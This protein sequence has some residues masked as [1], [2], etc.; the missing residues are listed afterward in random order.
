ME[1][2]ISRKDAIKQ[3]SRIRYPDG[4]QEIS[5]PTL[6]R[7]RNIAK[8]DATKNFNAEQF[9]RLCRIA[10]LA[11][12]GLTY[13]QI[14]N[15]IGVQTNDD[16]QQKQRNQGTQASQCS[17]GGGIPNTGNPNDILEYFYRK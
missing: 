16:E 8:C 5:S 7:W 3:L 10:A 13:E 12:Q 4:G 15:H 14:A 11:Y 2:F 9:G 1:R 17:Q 6:H